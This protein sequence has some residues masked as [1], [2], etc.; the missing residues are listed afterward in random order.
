[1]D[2]FNIK[3]YL[4]ESTSF[5]PN[6]GTM[7][8]GVTN[9]DKREYLTE[10]RLLKEADSEH[11]EAFAEE[12][13]LNIESLKAEWEG[14]KDNYDSIEDYVAELSDNI[15]DTRS[16]HGDELNEVSNVDPD[17][18]EDRKYRLEEFMET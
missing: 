4:K 10:G 5:T 8:G 15:E 2:T 17:T 11:L 18:V 1:M 6:S 13:D 14:S 16:F 9:L 12:N 7:S 3:Q